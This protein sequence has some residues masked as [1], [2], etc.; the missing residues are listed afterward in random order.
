MLKTGVDS[1]RETPLARSNELVFLQCSV[2]C[3]QNPHWQL[4]KSAQEINSM[5]FGLTYWGTENCELPKQMKCHFEFLQQVVDKFKHYNFKHGSQCLQHN[6]PARLSLQKKE[7][8]DS[9]SLKKGFCHSKSWPK[10]GN[11]PYGM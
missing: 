9:C 5:I 2:T 4:A 3:Y 6:T 10:S 1:A 11:S 8:A 7:W